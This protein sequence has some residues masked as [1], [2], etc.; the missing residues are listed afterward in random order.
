MSKSVR[1][2]DEIGGRELLATGREKNLTSMDWGSID[3][4]S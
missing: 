4:A 3:A 1:A 2:P